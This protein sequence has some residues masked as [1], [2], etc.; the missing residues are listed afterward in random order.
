MDWRR[1]WE[2]WSDGGKSGFVG[3]ESDAL[4]VLLQHGLLALEAG[5]HPATMPPLRAALLAFSLGMTPADLTADLPVAE[6]EVIAC[7]ILQD[8]LQTRAD[9]RQRGV[10]RTNGAR[11][12]DGTNRKVLVLQ[13]R[14]SERARTR[15]AC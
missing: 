11:S 3:G 6:L 8:R 10:D 13:W 15:R 2:T 1:K 5:V 14:H 12:W 4:P 7:A 9:G